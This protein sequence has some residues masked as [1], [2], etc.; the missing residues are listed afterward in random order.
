[1]AETEIKLSVSRTIRTAEFESLNIS[2][3]I[4]ETVEWFD[5]ISRSLATDQVMNHLISDFSKAYNS[6]TESIGVRRSLGVGKLEDKK[7]YTSNTA[8]VEADCDSVDIF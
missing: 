7:K 3:E 6:I 1:M 2:T 4:R 8:N 5:E